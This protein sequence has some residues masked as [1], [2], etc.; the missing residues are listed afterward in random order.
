MTHQAGRAKPGRTKA[1]VQ[2]KAEN[3]LKPYA[4]HAMAVSE[5]VVRVVEPSGQLEHSGLAT[6]LLPPA[7]KLPTPH[8]AQVAPP[9]PGAQTTRVRGGTRVVMVVRGVTSSA[10]GSRQHDTYIRQAELSLAGP[11]RGSNHNKTGKMLKPHHMRWRS[12][13]QWSGC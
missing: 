2:S 5:P 6:A 13:S 11:R 9:R 3:M 8:T 10:C 12:G 1:G 4:P 7:E